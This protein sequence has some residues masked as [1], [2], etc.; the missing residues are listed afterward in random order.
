MGMRASCVTETD[1]SC[2]TET[3]HG[4]IYE[5][6]ACWEALHSNMSIAVVTYKTKQT[7]VGQRDNRPRGHGI[8]LAAQMHI[9]RPSLD[10]N[11]RVRQL[12]SLVHNMVQQTHVDPI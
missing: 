4:W 2:V 9:G 5:A 12:Q 10:P 8:H 3:D 6:A 11:V 1:H 7:N